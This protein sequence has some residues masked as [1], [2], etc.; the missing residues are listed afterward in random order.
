M[1]R[2]P[3]VESSSSRTRNCRILLSSSRSRQE[4][5]EAALDNEWRELRQHVVIEQDPDMMLRLAAEL[6]RRR[7]SAEI[8]KRRD[9]F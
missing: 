2:S 1:N 4:A 7:R 3:S 5:L 8:V 6:E 9:S